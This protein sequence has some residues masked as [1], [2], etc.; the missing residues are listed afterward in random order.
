MEEKRKFEGEGNRANPWN[1]RIRRYI[2]NIGDFRK[3]RGKR[4]ENGRGALEYW[5]S[6]V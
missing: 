5:V 4:N 1:A 3:A 2:G 6:I